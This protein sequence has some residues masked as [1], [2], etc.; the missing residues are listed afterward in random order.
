MSSSSGNIVLTGFMGSGK[1]HFAH[2]L[3]KELSYDFLDT[4]NLIATNQKS[5]IKDIFDTKGEAFFRQE[6]ARTA[7]F[8]E[9]H[10]QNSIIATGGG[11]PI[12]YE[13]TLAIGTVFYMDISFEDIL[14]RMNEDEKAKRPLFNDIKEAKK[15][16]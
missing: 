14:K 2:V 6:E 16:F 15:T 5:T 12:F 10:I 9:E 4:D 1:S 7:K 11:L 8:I 3:A 13:D